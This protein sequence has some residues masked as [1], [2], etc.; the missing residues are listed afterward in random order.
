MET[1]SKRRL[2]TVLD[3]VS[4]LLKGREAEFREWDRQGDISKEFIQQM[5][6]FGL[7]SLI[8]PRSLAGWVFRRPAIRERYK[9]L[10]SND[11]SIAVT[12]GAHS[13]L[14]CEASYSLEPRRRKRNI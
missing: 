4:S 6:E 3:S 14:E 2:K 9:R 7:F 12:V 13:S 10:L 5:R 11:A 8:I 1:R